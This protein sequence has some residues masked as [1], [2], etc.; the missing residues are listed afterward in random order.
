MMAS[1]PPQELSKD[2]VSKFRFPA[3]IAAEKARQHD[4]LTGRI[5]LQVTVLYNITITGKDALSL[6]DSI[7]SEIDSYSVLAAAG[8]LAEKIEI[9]AGYFGYLCVFHFL[10][11]NRYFCHTGYTD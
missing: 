6:M 5:L 9:P 1:F 4:E 10:Q 8:Q 11:N 2:T 3:Q 7:I